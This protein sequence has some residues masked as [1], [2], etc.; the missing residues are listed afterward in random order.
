MRSIAK[1][2]KGAKYIYADKCGGEHYKG[3]FRHYVEYTAP[4]TSPHVM[5]FTLAETP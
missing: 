5:S 4:V 3:R 2:P 1:V